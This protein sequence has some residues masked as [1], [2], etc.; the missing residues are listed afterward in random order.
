[1][2][3]M[4]FGHDRSPDV[5][6]IGSERVVPDVGLAGGG[7]WGR[8]CSWREGGGGMGELNFSRESYYTCIAVFQ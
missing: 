1:M 3:Y 2:T 8:R 7:Q 4:T 6:L 5:T